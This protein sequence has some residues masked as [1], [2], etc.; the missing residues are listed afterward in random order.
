MKHLFIINPTAAR[1][2]G[3]NLENMRQE[4]EAFFAANPRI[5]HEVH[6]TRWKRDATGFV[7]R[8][9]SRS[10]ELVRVYAVGGNG[11]LF[12]VVNSCACVP[13]VQVA[14]LPMGR[15]NTA[16]NSFGGKGFLFRSLWNLSTAGVI[17]LDL[18][19]AGDCYSLTGCCI[20]AGVAHERESAVEASPHKEEAETAV[21]PA[22]LIERLFLPRRLYVQTLSF[23][24]LV[25]QNSARYQIEIDGESLDGEYLNILVANTPAASGQH[26]AVWTAM[27][28]GALDLYLIKQPPAR[29]LARIVSDF[30]FG[31]YHAWAEYFIHRRGKSVSISGDA[32]R[33]VTVDEERFY[34]SSPF[35]LDFRLVPQ[36][37]D[38]VLPGGIGTPRGFV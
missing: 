17:S 12:E 30:A 28:D 20:G 24:E 9:V 26:P 33:H 27:A 31:R 10:G 7:R 35:S 13:N 16:L 32:A 8:F 1:L 21:R 25:K 38:F 11:T 34:T 6:V 36:S 3:G 22:R 18:I 5:C 14:F 19:H 23:M 2:G 37:I 15:N 4:I 29:R